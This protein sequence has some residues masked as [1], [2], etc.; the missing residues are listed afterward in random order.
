MYNRGVHPVKGGSVMNYLIATDSF[1]GSLTSMEAAKCMRE[2]IL[3]VFPDAQITMMPAA[4]GGEGTVEA[5]LSG[6]EGKAVTE[7][8]S[9]PLGRPVEAKFAILDTGE[10]VIEMAQA[11][12]LLL[13]EPS[14]RDVLSATTYGTGQLI[15][16]VMDMGCRKICIGIGGSATNDAGAGMAQALG[17]RFLSKDGE[18]LPGGGG[19]LGNLARIDC[20][21]L[22]PR[23][24]ET[25]ILVMCDVNNPLCGPEG[26]SRIYG[27]QKGA[28]PAMVLE[29][30]KNLEHFAN[31]VE[32]D[33][34]INARNYPG[35]GAAGGLG[36]GLMCFTGA[37]LV[38]GI[39]AILDL[40][41]FDEKLETADVVVTGEGKLD[42]QTMRGKVI[43][44]V[45]ERCEK[46]GIPV[47]AVCG[48]V[49][50]QGRQVFG[51]RFRAIVA[52][53]DEAVPLDLAI[54][55]AKVLLTNATERII[56]KLFAAQA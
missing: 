25:E 44:G 6:M 37:R 40:S 18:D 32:K 15:K 46:M 29:L 30:D 4:D 45:L 26:A 13:V 39:D 16:K 24:K 41:A 10:A 20:S 51:K 22:D 34:K 17:V 38:R 43:F 36:M 33:L 14:K 31:I 12:G 5:I 2:G 42:Q 28:T 8:V 55:N 1:K 19:S 47:I 54:K 53:A 50:D 35:A 27:P 9:D 52:A 48:R 21:A 56:R 49:T 7:T 11:S 3:K 23:L